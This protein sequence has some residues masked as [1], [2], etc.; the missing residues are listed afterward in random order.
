ME[1]FQQSD[2][3]TCESYKGLCDYVYAIGDE[4]KPGLVHCNLEEIPAFFD[5]IRDNGYDYVV[6]SSCS[7]FGLGYLVENPPWIDIRKWAMMSV[8]PEVGFRGLQIPARF[9]PSKVNPEHPYTVKCYSYTF[10]TLPEIP[11]NVHKWFMTNSLIFPTR[12]PVIEVLP[13]GI[14][15]KSED[16]IFNMMTETAGIEKQGSTYVNF[17]NYTYE[18]Y[19][20]K[21]AFRALQLPYVTIVEDAK[22]YEDYLYDLA[23]HHYAYAPEGNGVDCYRTLEAIYMG[24]YPVVQAG[25]TH[26]TLM[27]GLDTLV[28]STL[29]GVPP[30]YLAAM[31]KWREQNLTGNDFARLSYWKGRFAE[32]RAKWATI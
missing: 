14:A 5:A 18:R 32:E 3:I 31:R 28:S 1:Q 21:E 2:I 26:L 25:P 4:P 13:F 12:E 19:A 16:K 11:S 10:Y 7:D 27:R 15:A 24:T 17:T 30:D 6:V 29:L 23:T 20:I 9:E 22:P 8:G